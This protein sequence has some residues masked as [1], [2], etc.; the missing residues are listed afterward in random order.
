[1]KCKILPSD[2]IGIKYKKIKQEIINKSDQKENKNK[3]QVPYEHKD[4]DKVLLE[5]PGIL[6]LLSTPLTGPNPVTNVCKSGKIRIKK[7]IVSEI[8]E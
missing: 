3:I 5:T 1:V 6:Q 7:R 4:G 8:T 2:Q